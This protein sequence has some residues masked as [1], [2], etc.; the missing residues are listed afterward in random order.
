MCTYHGILQEYPLISIDSFENYNYTS[1]I[2]FITHVHM[3]HLIGLERP[4]FGRYVSKIKAPIY[5]SDISRQMLSTMT[6]FRHLIPYFKSVCLD[7]P[8]TLT[9]RSNDPVQATKKS[10]EDIESLKTN[11][12]YHAP[13]VDETIVVTC[14][15]SGHCP[16]SIMIWIEGEQGNVLFTGDFRLYHGQAQRLE[17][18]HQQRTDDD[19]DHIYRFKPIDNLYIDMTFFRPNILHIPTREV[20]CQALI[21]WMKTLMTADTSDVNFHL[22]TR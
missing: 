5:M 11:L 20:C 13:N 3:D 8:F 22:K 7:Q 9:I 21:L 14:F 17:H 15:G 10:D 16:G 19:D 4:E 6:P 18:L 1:T 2:F 12:S